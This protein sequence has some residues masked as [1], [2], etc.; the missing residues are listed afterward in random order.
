MQWLLLMGAVAIGFFV[1]VFGPLLSNG[2]LARFESTILY[3]AIP[4]G[5]LVILSRGHWGAL[6]RSVGFRDVLLMVAFAILNTIVTLAVGLVTMNV[7]TRT[8]NPAVASLATQSPVDVILFYARTMVQL[9]GEELMTILPFLA[10]MYL[11]VTRMGLSR[12][13][14]ILLAWLATAVLFAAEHL[15]TYRF[16]VAQAL[17]G[18]GVARLVLTLPYIMTKNLWVP[19][20]A[21]VLNDWASFSLALFGA[22]HAPGG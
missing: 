2:T 17:L 20:G 13:A 6:F 1:L 19:T 7:I 3:V 18:V 22:A 16:N 10:L 11:F 14:G 8:P 9:F 12:A 21:H 4:L 5:T 15:Q